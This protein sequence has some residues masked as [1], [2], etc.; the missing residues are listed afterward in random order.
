MGRT[1]YAVLSIAVALG[2]VSLAGAES[3][4]AMLE[5]GI[6]A[7]ETKGDL[8]AAIEIYKQIVEDAKAHRRYAAEAQF[9]LGVCHLKKQEK[10][11]AIEAFRKVASEFPGETSI[12]AKA[13]KELD[14]LGANG[15]RPP[16]VVKTTPAGFA[17]AVSP[18]VSK[19]SVTFDQAMNEKACCWLGNDKAPKR[20]GEWS[21]D[22]ATKTWSIPVKLE[23]GKVYSVDINVR[24]GGAF[25]NTEGALAPHH[26]IVFA[27]KGADGKPTPLPDDVVALAKSRNARAREAATAG[28]KAAKKSL[29]LNPAPWADGEVMRLRLNS[30]AGPEMGTLVYT[31]DSIKTAGKDV[32][33]IQSFLLIPM[34]N[35]EQ[36]THVDAERDGFAPITGRTKNSMGDFRAE[37]DAL[38]VKLTTETGGEKT[39]R[40]FTLDQVAYDNEQAL[41]LI[42]RMPLAVGYH[43]SFP[44]FPVQGGTVV[45]CRIEVT[46][47]EKVT[48][49]AGTV[50]T[51]KTE[52][53][54]WAETVKALQHQ[55]W[56]SA[57]KHHYLVKYDSGSAVMELT[58][59][60]ATPRKHVP[61]VYDDKELG[62]SLTTPAGWYFYRNPSPG[63]Y[64]F[65]LRLLPPALKAWCLLTAAEL[66]PLGL[67]AREVAEGDVGALKGF[68]KGYTVRPDSWKDLKVSG[69]PAAH[70]IADYQDEKKDMVE[71]RT[72]ILG[73]SA[74]YWFVFRSEK[75]LFP[76]SEGEFDKIVES[77]RAGK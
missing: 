18:S 49:P 31:A 56:F 42:R 45:E 10:D 39:T 33:R 73:K 26:V 72:Y 51:Y 65:D 68:F 34:V 2:A 38:K 55:L 53:S 64:K 1:S 46:G 8:D 44:I 21:Y 22:A 58:E 3:P 54:V 15:G 70:Y 32:W 36:F 69:M 6:F 77:L 75:G 5:K 74:V 57:D 11:K 7:E 48:V 63:T 24:G 28:G 52:L 71:Y 61:G 59:V 40:D 60:P 25:R 14:R 76:G 23:P 35:H 47:K 4:A 43:G 12:V 50:E 19:I 41:F 67:S 29:K 37:Y 13:R 66:G 27:T 9:R 62:I 30:P 16:L 17:D 20:T